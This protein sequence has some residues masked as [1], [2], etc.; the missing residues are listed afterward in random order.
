MKKY[1]I[2]LCLITRYQLEIDMQ[3]YIEHYNST[4]VTDIFVY[5][6]ES[7]SN[8]KNVCEKYNNVYYT[9]IDENYIC[10]NP[11]H[12]IYTDF[13]NN[14]KNEYDYILC[15]DD[16]EYLWLN[17]KKYNDLQ[18][19]CEYMDKE[20]IEQYILPWQYISYKDN[21]R[22]YKRTNSMIEDCHYTYSDYFKNSKI[23]V[24][25][26]SIVSTKSDVYYSYVH[27]F[28]D[29][30]GNYK[31]W[32]N[33]KIYT[34]GEVIESRVS[35]DFREADII[36]FHYLHR[37]IEEWEI[38][39]KGPSCDRVCNSLGEKYITI[40]KKSITIPNGYSEYINPFNQNKKT[41]ELDLSIFIK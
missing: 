17:K 34:T 23:E 11:Q 15:L 20:N 30:N 31:L 9:F 24:G 4:G 6:N 39:M 8:I 5:D 13:Y 3:K 28:T 33:N 1:K 25:I 35:I 10:K 29:I 36:L 40:F 18:D 41:N 2:A 14:H 12:K 21:E 37:S 27:Y 19:F 26:K 16:D 22:P 32:Y 7:K 38:K